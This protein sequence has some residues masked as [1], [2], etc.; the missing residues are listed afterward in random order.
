MDFRMIHLIKASLSDA[1][2]AGERSEVYMIDLSEYSG[3]RLKKNLNV[4]ELRGDALGSPD[5]R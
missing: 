4:I 1:H 3:S 2:A 5:N